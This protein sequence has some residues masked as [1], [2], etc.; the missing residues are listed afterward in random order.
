M[1]NKQF[2]EIK[3]LL[4][5]GD[6]LEVNKYL[7]SFIYCGKKVNKQSHKM[8]IDFALEKENVNTIHLVIGLLGKNASSKTLEYLINKI[9]ATDTT[10]YI[11]ALGYIMDKLSLE[12][13]DKVV[14]AIITSKS[15]AY[16]EY[17]KSGDSNAFIE[18]LSHLKCEYINSFTSVARGLKT[19]NI[20]KLAQCFSS[21]DDL[22]DICKL[23]NEANLPKDKMIE[24]ERLILE[25]Y[26]KF[27]VA[28]FL[29]DTNN[30]E[31][32]NLIYG[33]KDVLEKFLQDDKE[34]N[35]DI[36]I[37]LEKQTSI[38][39]IFTI[40]KSSKCKLKDNIKFPLCSSPLKMHFSTKYKYVDDNIQMVLNSNSYFKN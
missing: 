40:G 36:G 9:I 11:C 16:H 8:L 13:Q 22:K 14:D 24:I 37:P 4:K 25:S 7:Y 17:N 1:K 31:L 2:F 32:I 39:G 33:D 18:M 27:E 35:I 21:Y 15:K 29:K 26:N 6:E 30:T 20:D 12:T 38:N 3:D 34:C 28:L 5:I 23:L 10:D 19:S